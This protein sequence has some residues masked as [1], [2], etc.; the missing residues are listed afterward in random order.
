MCCCCAALLDRSVSS[1]MGFSYKNTWAEFPKAN[2]T[3]T[4][5]SLHLRPCEPM[6]RLPCNHSFYILDINTC[7]SSPDFSPAAV[8]HIRS[9]LAFFTRCEIRTSEQL[10]SKHVFPKISCAL[11][12]WGKKFSFLISRDKTSVM[13]GKQ[14]SKVFLFKEEIIIKDCLCIV[15][16]EQAAQLTEKLQQSDSFTG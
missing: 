10:Q 1:L 14:T 15:I 4:C 3:P 2:V 8:K 13:T 5:S 11:D 6:T 12:F 7:D 16:S 9:L